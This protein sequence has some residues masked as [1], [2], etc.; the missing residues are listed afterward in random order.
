[1]TTARFP[2]GF[3]WGTATAAHQVEGNNRANDWWAWE[4]TSGH[5]KNGD[6]SERAC[7][8]YHRFPSDFELLGSL[9]QNA[10]RLSVEWSRIE[11]RRGQF[12]PEALEHYREVL[13]ALRE[14]GMEPMVTLHHFTNPTWIADL[15]AW[16]EAKTAEHFADFAARVVDEYHDLVRYWVT[17]NEPTVVAY[18]GYVRGEWPPG[19][20]YD[21]G[22]VA[23][24]LTTLMRAHWL[25]YE[26]IKSR[27]PQAQLGL[28]HHIRLFDPARAWMPLD[29]AVAWAFDRVFNRTTLKTLQ[30]GKLVFPLTSAGRATGPTP[31]QDFLGLNY[32]TRDLVKFNRRYRDELF[33][34]R[35][36]PAEAQ[37]SDLGWEIYPDGLYRALRGLAEFRLPVIVT[38]NGIADDAD[39]MRAAYLLSHLTAVQRAIADGVPVRGY[40]HWT[41]MDNFEWAEGYSAKFGLIACDPQTQER[42]LRPSARLYAEICRTNTL[43]AT[44]E[45]PPAPPAPARAG[46]PAE[47]R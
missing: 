43:P 1:L 44:V 10:H 13:T 47:L 45:L 37:R 3:L 15:G 41:A 23:R 24:V 39:R 4:Q 7:E 25:A 30:T 17:I 18:Q 46:G 31:S 34:E 20:H 29:R 16:E 5:V 36:M 28:A 33:G 26:R 19:K 12:S 21:L 8:H 32:Y 38:E 9:H 40:F 14:R 11:P 22:Q 6:S 35:V 27:H 2:D 42:R